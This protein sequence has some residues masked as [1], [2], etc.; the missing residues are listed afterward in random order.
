VLKFNVKVLNIS[1]NE[2][3]NAIVTNDGV[4]YYWGKNLKE[5]EQNL[6]KPIKIQYDKKIFRIFLGRDFIIG[7]SENNKLVA[8]GNGSD[9]QMG[10]GITQKGFKENFVDINMSNFTINTK[11]KKETNQKEMTVSDKVRTNTNMPKLMRKTTKKKTSTISEAK[12]LSVS[13]CST[14]CVA[15]V[16]S[17]VFIWGKISND[18]ISG[19][20]WEPQQI[21]E[22]ESIQIKQIV[23]SNSIIYANPGLQNKEEIV[24]KSF[25]PP[26]V[27]CGSQKALVN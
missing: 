15:L 25:D 5:G 12:I 21:S 7:I 8:M 4:V 26:I 17:K 11:N 3:N 9:G 24:Y 2:Y 27:E 22:L 16:N 20:F 19:T 18:E 23:C 13:C 10:A 1:C 14:Y 6:E